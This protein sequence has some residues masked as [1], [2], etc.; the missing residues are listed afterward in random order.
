MAGAFFAGS[1]LGRSLAGRNLGNAR[2][3]CGGSLLCWGR[4]REPELAGSLFE[5]CFDVVEAVGEA[6]ELLGNLGLDQADEVLGL[7]AAALD[8]ILNRLLGVLAAQFTRLDEV[9]DDLFGV[10]L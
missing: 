9:G 6:A 3:A 1:L 4:R 8:E 7:G 5:T 2:W 10:L